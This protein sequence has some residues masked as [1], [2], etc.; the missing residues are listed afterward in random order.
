ML[1]NVISPCYM[2]AH[3]SPSRRS[4][5]CDRE[6]LLALAEASPGAWLRSSH[7]DHDSVPGWLPAHLFGRA[8]RR[9]SDDF[10]PLGAPPESAGAGRP[11]GKA[12]SGPAHPTNRPTAPTVIRALEAESR[13]LWAAAGSVGWPHAGV[14]FAPTVRR[15]VEGSAGTVLVTPFGLGLEACP[16]RLPS[17]QGRRCREI[18]SPGKKRLRQR[19]KNEV[20]IFEDETG[21]SQPPRMSRVWARKGEPFRVPMRREPRK[22]LNILGWVDPLGG[23]HG[24]R[25]AAQG[26]TQGFL[27]LLRQLRRSWQNHPSWGG[28]SPWA[29]RAAGAEVPG[30]T[31]R[32]AFEVLP[33]IK[34]RLNPQER[35]WH[36]VRY[37]R[38][39]NRWFPD[40][41]ET[42]KAIR[43]TSR[44]WS[45]HKVKR[46]CNIL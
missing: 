46:L 19:R 34:P 41:D 35:I 24:M 38:T 6:R 25:R 29:P 27:R 45:V 26:N 12:A 14:A 23:R 42:W 9:E 28:R 8:F 13:A 30:Q 11:A 16:R 20:L 3:E 32:C 39:N 31:S 5:R 22:R 44:R 7:C 18:P 21:F 33:P 37:E 10:D 2:G 4:Y 43:D 15:A 17:S 1:H 36:Q 40:L